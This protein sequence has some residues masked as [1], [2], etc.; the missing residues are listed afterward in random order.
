V[1]TLLKINKIVLIVKY[2]VC[3]DVQDDLR[4]VRHSASRSL[5]YLIR[6]VLM[7]LFLF[8]FF[9]IRL[10]KVENDLFFVY[11]FCSNVGNF[12]S[13]FV[14][15]SEIAIIILWYARRVY[16]KDLL[17]RTFA[18]LRCR[19]KIRHLLVHRRAVITTLYYYTQKYSAAFVY[20]RIINVYNMGTSVCVGYIVAYN[21]LLRLLIGCIFSP[22]A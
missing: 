1:N 6:F 9:V 14:H 5:I 20:R 18:H 10:E 4:D 3:G 2:H 12:K 17:R 11:S 22:R 7:A 8:Y 15:V 16:V 21:L 13:N 19:R